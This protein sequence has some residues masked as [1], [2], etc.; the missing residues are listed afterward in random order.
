MMNK[1]T[2]HRQPGI[3]AIFHLVPG[4]PAAHVLTGWL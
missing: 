2:R 4:L 3:G 1:D